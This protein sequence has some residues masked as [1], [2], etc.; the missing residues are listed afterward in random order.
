MI[1]NV[2]VC[3]V[4]PC[5]AAEAT[6]GRAIESVAAQSAAPAEVILVDDASHDRTAAAIEDLRRRT[7]PFGLRARRLSTNVGPGGAR[8]EGWEMIDPGMRYVAFL[9]ADD[10]WL[11]RKLER[12]MAWMDVHDDVSWTAHRCGVLG[13]PIASESAATRISTCPL[14]RRMLLMR[15]AV[16]TPTVMVRATVP[17][18]FR[19]GWRW[20]EDLML[21]LDWLDQGRRGTMLDVTLALL[22]RSPTTPGGATGNLA[23]MYGGERRVIDRLVGEGRMSPLMGAAWRGYA[24]AR[25]AR[26]RVIA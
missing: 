19:P 14:T 18:R 25:Y 15:N 8:N 4:V 3:V 26:R 2:P 10:V 21:W 13:R 12:Q 5:H 20:C 1:Q 16:A 6:L 22:G 7:W 24:L 17:E 9:D 23:A 11:P